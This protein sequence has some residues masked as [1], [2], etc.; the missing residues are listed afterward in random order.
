MACGQISLPVQSQAVRV[1]T[2]RS[3]VR[4]RPRSLPAIQLVR[5]SVNSPRNGFRGARQ[6]YVDA[7]LFKNMHFAESFNVQLRLQAYNVFNHL[8]GYR[9][10]NNLSDGNFGNDTAEQRRRQLEFGVRFI[11]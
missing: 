4:Q 7:S 10:V 9:I 1:L 2:V 8:N 6:E 11:F 3:F 5:N